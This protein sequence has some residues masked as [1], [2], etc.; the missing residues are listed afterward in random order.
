MLLTQQLETA[1]IGTLFFEG[2][3]ALTFYANVSLCV[4]LFLGGLES[5]T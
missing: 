2:V 1:E 4:T 5:G 3:I